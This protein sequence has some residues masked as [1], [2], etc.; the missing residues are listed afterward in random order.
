MVYR[1]GYLLLD[2]EDPR[3]IIYRSQ[4][5]VF[6]PQ[7]SYELSGIVDVLPTGLKEIQR[8]TQDK[9]NDYLDRAMREGFMPQVTFCPAALLIDG[10]IRIYYGASDSVICTAKA[11]LERIWEVE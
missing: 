3:K 1:L 11:P 2:L 6:G 8:M 5:P 10:D 7:E 4:N 9:W